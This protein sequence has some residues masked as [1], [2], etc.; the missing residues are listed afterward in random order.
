[1]ACI[2]VPHSAF[3]FDEAKN[4]TTKGI[5]FPGWSNISKKHEEN[6]KDFNPHEIKT[7]GIRSVAH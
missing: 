5:K 4:R 7:S 3:V 6:G 2:A 1:M